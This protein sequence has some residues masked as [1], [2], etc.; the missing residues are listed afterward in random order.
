MDQEPQP[1]GAAVSALRSPTG[2]TAAKRKASGVTGHYADPMSPIASTPMKRQRIRNPGETRSYGFTAATS[3]LTDRLLRREHQVD[4]DQERGQIYAIG[5]REWLLL[6][7]QAPRRVHRS[8][9]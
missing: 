7:S 8:R 9:R 2:K 4:Q 6:A 5:A 1:K 3:R